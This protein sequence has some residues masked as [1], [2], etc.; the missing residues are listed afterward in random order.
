MKRSLEALTCVENDTDRAGQIIGRIRDQIKK[1]PPRSESF[2]LTKLLKQT[3]ALAGREAVRHEVSVKTRLAPE[4][5]PVRGDRIQLQQVLLNLIYNAIEAMIPA[6]ESTREMWI[7]TGQTGDGSV[8][9]TVR[10]SGMGIGPEDLERVFKAFYT[11]K[12]NGVG[13]GLS[14][15]RSIVE[16]HGGRL[17]AEANECGGAKFHFTLPA[18]K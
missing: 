15:C 7:G 2:D 5:P 1:T 6:D 10:D 16:A 11:T 9:V 8:L 13:I 18:E 17:W 12:P 14:L 3:L 4:L